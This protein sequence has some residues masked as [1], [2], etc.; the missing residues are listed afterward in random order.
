M[1]MLDYQVF[2]FFQLMGGEFSAVRQ[3]DWTQPKFAFLAFLRDMHVGGFIIFVRIK[4]E[5]IRL[6]DPDRWHGIK[7]AAAS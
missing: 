1:F 7:M 6:R 2:D 5:F 4:T 3:P